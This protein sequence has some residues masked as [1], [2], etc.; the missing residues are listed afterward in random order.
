M[1]SANSPAKASR[2]I[3]PALVEAIAGQLERRRNELVRRLERY[4]RAES[5]STD[6]PALDRFA[7][8]LA[9]DCRRA[10]ARVELLTA[11]S[12]GDHVVARFEGVGNAKPILLL[13]HYDTVYPAG[14]LGRMPFRVSGKWVMGP[15]ALDMKSGLA[16]ALGAIGALRAARV[17]LPGPVVC[18][19]TSDEEVG[20]GTSRGHIE[21]LA[22]KARAVLVLEPAAGRAGKLKTGRKGVGE[23]ELIVHGKSSHAGL[24]PEQGINAI[25]E[26]ALQIERI[27][28]FNDPARGTTVNVDVVEGGTRSNVIAERAKASIDLRVSRMKDAAALEKRFRALRPVLRGAQL[29][30]HGGIN[31]PPMERSAGVAAL[32]RQAQAVGRA[33]GM[34]LAEAVVGGG[35]DGNFTAALG[36]PTL[37]GLGAV[38]EGAHS[39]GE[40]VELKS[41]GERAAVLALLVA[42][43]DT[44]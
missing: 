27:R 44:R 13:G 9:A 21:R 8:M 17:R 32:F 29:E 43:A 35:S 18:L 41:L 31:R 19:F 23:I 6:K 22:R 11:K 12:A 38:G 24:N 36:V 37:D 3:D 10:G 2:G 5:P 16:M 20:S 33:L 15:G 34:R 28:G 4:V 25:H 14:T 39:P 42:T 1:R 7:R 30:I 40:K 26:L